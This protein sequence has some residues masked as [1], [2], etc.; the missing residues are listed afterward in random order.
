MEPVLSG[1]QQQA[2]AQSNTEN[3]VETTEYYPVSKIHKTIRRK[4]NVLL[5]V[6]EKDGKGALTRTEYDGAHV[7]CITEVDENGH[8]RRMT[9]SPIKGKRA[10]VYLFAY[11][12]NG[13]LVKQKSGFRV[14][15]LPVVTEWW[16]KPV[17]HTHF[18]KWSGK[19][20]SFEEGHEPDVNEYE[21]MTKGVFENGQIVR[22]VACDFM[23]HPRRVLRYRK[24]ALTQEVLY[25]IRGGLTLQRRYNTH[26]EGKVVVKTMAESIFNGRDKCVGMTF[27]ETRLDSE[28]KPQL[29]YIYRDGALTKRIIYSRGNSK[30][31]GDRMESDY[32]Y[33]GRCTEDKFLTASGQL[34]SA[35]RYEYND[36]GRC[37]DTYRWNGQDWLSETNHDKNAPAALSAPPVVEKSAL[38]DA[39]IRPFPDQSRAGM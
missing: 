23:D 3:I 20:V 33:D 13:Y 8:L 17:R 6:T 16:R 27:V 4:G 10:H 28:L 34:L 25:E 1:K 22:V 32:R 24:G 15:V 18:S 35:L 19:A 2:N 30:R 5:D 31:Q 11:D 12:N 36:R 14:P 39:A 29:T 7:T 9:C 26:R 37:V 38:H 21:G